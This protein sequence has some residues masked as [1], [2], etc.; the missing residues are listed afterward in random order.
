MVQNLP[1]QACFRRQTAKTANN[2]LKPVL[3][4]SGN[5]IGKDHDAGIRGIDHLLPEERKGTV[6]LLL[7]VQPELSIGK[8]MQEA[9]LASCRE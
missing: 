9:R 7:S 8:E 4:K 1:F 3:Y 2:A 6:P 5:H